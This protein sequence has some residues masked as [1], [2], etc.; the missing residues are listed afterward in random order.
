MARIT[1]FFFLA[2]TSGYTVHH[3]TWYYSY[4]IILTGTHDGIVIIRPLQVLL[5]FL[6]PCLH[7]FGKFQIISILNSLYAACAK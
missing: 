2:K 7:A 4:C 5:L 1:T 3:P 6:V